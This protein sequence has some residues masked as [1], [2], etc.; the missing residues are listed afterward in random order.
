VVG[1]GVVG[2]ILVER[3]ENGVQEQVRLAGPAAGAVDA[4]V[5]E[6][7]AAEL[8]GS[9]RSMLVAVNPGVRGGRRSGEVTVPAVPYGVMIEQG[10]V[11]RRTSR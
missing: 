6:A 5:V 10:A 1:D 4:A 2:Q 9:V 11:E 3:T 8:A 7:L